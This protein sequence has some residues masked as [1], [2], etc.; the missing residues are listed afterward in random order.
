MKYISVDVETTGLN[1]E[2]DQILQIAMILED[3]ERPVPNPP[4]LNIGI[5]RNRISGDMKAMALNSKIIKLL[6]ETKS[7]KST[8]TYNCGGKDIEMELLHESNVVYEV[9]SWLIDHGFKLDWDDRIRITC[10][11]K[12]FGAFDK[13]FLERLP[14]W[15]DRIAIR[16]RYLDPSILY[17]NW[18]TD[19]EPPSL[20]ECIMRAGFNY[21]EATEHIHDAY[22]DAMM[23]I[24]L[25]RKAY[26]PSLE[27]SHSPAPLLFS[28]EGGKASL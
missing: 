21:Q 4:Y 12:N 26:V 11:G 28:P 6:G 16:Q 27:A 7:S 24:K 14:G 15:K 19:T 1:P 17:I 2:Q 20:E 3:T 5:K 22:F 8:V 9:A 25:L 18:S 10:A 13:L 23:I